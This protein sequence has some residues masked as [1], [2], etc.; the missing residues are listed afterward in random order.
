MRH[1]NPSPACNPLSGLI[2][3]TLIVAIFAGGL[4]ILTGV[5]VIADAKPV[6]TL[7]VCHPIGGVSYNLSQGEAPLI[8]AHPAAQ[9]PADWSAAPQFDAVFPPG[10]S[11]APDPPPP[12]IS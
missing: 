2:A 10:P 9:P 5:V 8:P 4:P 6:F 12:K 7:D 1:R 11:Q 3:S